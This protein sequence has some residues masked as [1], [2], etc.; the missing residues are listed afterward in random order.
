MNT[1]LAKKCGT[2]VYDLKTS[3][4]ISIDE[5]LTRAER[6]VVMGMIDWYRIESADGRTWEA[7]VTIKDGDK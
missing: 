6:A 4:P 5:L 7:N 3:N 1:F 2:I